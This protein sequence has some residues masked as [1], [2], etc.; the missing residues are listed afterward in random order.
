MCTI[1][2][3]ADHIIERNGSKFGTRGPRNCMCR[4]LFMSDYLNSVWGHS[5]SA[6]CKIFNVKLIKR[7]LLP[8]FSSNF[9]Q[10]YR[11]HVIGRKI[12]ILLFLAICQI[13]KVYGT[14]KIS[15][16]SYIS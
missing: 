16:T 10:L 6:L 7:L 11:K 8:M 12:R 15:Y 13:L 9:N 4:V 14:L 3:K 5:A 1:L 2:K